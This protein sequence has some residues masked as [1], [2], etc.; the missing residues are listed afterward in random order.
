MVVGVEKLLI[1]VLFIEGLMMP[2]GRISRESVLNVCLNTLYTYM[3]CIVTVCRNNHLNSSH[4][5]L[6]GAFLLPYFK[7]DNIPLLLLLAILWLE[8]GDWCNAGSGSVRPALMSWCWARGLGGGLD[9]CQ[10]S[11]AG[12]STEISPHRI[13]HLTLVWS[14]LSSQQFDQFERVIGYCCL[15]EFSIWWI[16]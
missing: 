1:D 2:V 16:Q 6:I 11:L 3:D 9:S 15:H 8:E 12:Y 5:S 14:F 7:L 10:S 13:S 4:L